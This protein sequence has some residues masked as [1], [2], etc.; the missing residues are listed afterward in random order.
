M[1]PSRPAAAA[2]KPAAAPPVSEAPSA[3]AGVP[4]AVVSLPEAMARA[5]RAMEAKDYAAAIVAFNQAI[6]I[7][8][9]LQE[10]RDGMTAASE[11]YKV[12]KLEDEQVL[13]IRDYFEENEYSSALRVLYRLPATMD[14]ATVNRWKVNGWYNKGVAELL[15]AECREAKAS[16]DE[17]L[18]IDAGDEGAKRLSEFAEKALDV[19]KDRAYYAKVEAIGFRKLDDG[20]SAGS[21][22]RR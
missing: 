15:G 9:T 3:P 12:K 16:F 6:Q 7:D 2:P 1:P 17:A 21:D 5:K 10:A 20:V 13:R 4:R 22:G 18:A 11:A 19:P 8:P 14:A